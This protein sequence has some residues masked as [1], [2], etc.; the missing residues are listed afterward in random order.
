M[1]N[2]Y[3][4]GS[5]RRQRNGIRRTTCAGQIP[6]INPEWISDKGTAF[7]LPYLNRAV[8]VLPPNMTYGDTPRRTS[9]LHTPWSSNEVWRC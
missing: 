7:R 3:N 6:I 5:T 9:Y 8:F 2:Q 4:R 1:D